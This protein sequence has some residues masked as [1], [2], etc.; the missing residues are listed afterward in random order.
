M[1]EHRSPHLLLALVAAL[2]AAG[3]YESN[4]CG[5][6]E[7]C[8]LRDDDCDGLIDEGFADPDGAYRQLENCGTCGVSCTRAFPTADRVACLD[9]VEGPTCRIITCPE[10]T[11]P[12]GNG[13]CVPDVPVLC[14]PC[15]VD[16]DCALRDPDA[17]CLPTASGA[18]RCGSP[19]RDPADCPSGFSCVREGMESIGQ[20]VPDSG[21]CGCTAD[22][23][24]VELACLLDSPVTGMRCAGVQRCGADGPSECEPAL[25]EA[26]N[27]QDDD[28]DG[29]VDEDFRDAEGRYVARLHCGGCARP[30]VEPGPN[31]VATCLPEGAG[32]RCE[33]EC[34][35]GFV[36]VD[37]ILAN[38]CECERW[39]GEGPPPVIGGDADC[40]GTPDDTTDFV[41]VTAT[42][43][44][45]NPGTLASPLRT[46]QAALARG[47]AEGK[48]VLVSRGVYEGPFDLVGGVSLFGGYSPDFRDRDLELYPVLLERT[49]GDGGQPVLRCSAVRERTRVEGFTVQGSDATTAGVGS[50]AILLDGC[51][52]ELTLAAL[53]V[54]AGRA[55]DGIRG[56]DSSTNLADWGVGS[57]TELDGS[58][59]TEGRDGTAGD[60]CSRI[61]AGTGGAHRCR[62]VDVSGGDG[63]AAECPGAICMNGSACGNAGCTDFTVGGVCDI[64]RALRTAVPNPAAGAGRGPMPGAAGEL[65]YNAPTNRGVCNFCDDNPTLLRD[66]GNGGDGEE[67]R[68]GGGGG[69]CRE[70]PVFDADGRLSAGRGTEGSAGADGSGGGGGTAGG[71]YE[72]IGGTMGACSDRAG[73]SGGGG[74]SGGCGAP[75]AD[76]GQGGGE[77]IGIVVRLG[78]IDRGPSFDRVRVVTASGGNGG[79]GGIGAAGG[80]GGTGAPGG[81]GRFWCARTGGRGGDGGRGGAGGGGG[82][83]CGGGSHGVLVSTSADVSAYRDLLAAT[84]A[85]EAA[86]V[87]GR[88][89]RGGFSPGTSGTDGVDGSAE[90]IFVSPR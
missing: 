9:A 19:C 58:R 30:C 33:V 88:G 4:L 51:G 89:G 12:A 11:H 53:T 65:S 47:R 67:G 72:V 76:G 22:T 42:G 17:R 62:A 8:N 60:F 21:L 49:D 43:S 27:A 3:C 84:V 40:D 85:I 87:P 25:V 64:D 32:T 48:D 55:A 13:A 78:A 81:V 50:T 73:G 63:G 74:G 31:M 29:A 70:P 2:G 5:V 44:D 86:G 14:L 68:D 28:C 38:G 39:D 36:D 7:E 59:G 79:D 37:R 24:D 20:C 54:L 52:P 71:G 69:G 6:P 45:T 10:F 18:S 75:G 80:A 82:G 56:D 35:E 77:S 16:L 57:L 83:G 1:T 23:E 26:C 46:V 61:G 15:T 66:G 90:P 34:Q 41:Y